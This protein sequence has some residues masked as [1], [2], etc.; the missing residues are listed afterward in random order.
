MRVAIEQNGVIANII[1]V[2]NMNAAADLYPG[3]TVMDADASGVQMGWVSDGQG[4]YQAPPEPETPVEYQKLDSAALITLLET[5]GGMTQEQV[6]ACHSDPNMAYF[7]ILLQI[8]PYTSRDNPKLPAALTAL[9]ALGY[10]PNGAQA[11][12]DAWPTA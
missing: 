1:E 7:W 8:T 9:A 3:A 4:G 10:L 6:V 5:A 12:L 2:V 11:V